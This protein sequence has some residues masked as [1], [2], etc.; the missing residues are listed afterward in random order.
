MKILTQISDN[1]SQVIQ[2]F[3]AVSILKGVLP[4]DV[5]N[6]M[7]KYIGTINSNSAD[8]QLVA[9]ISGEQSHLDVNHPLMED[10][11]NILLKGCF[12]YQNF[13]SRDIHD[14]D[15]T[16]RTITL[17]S[18]WSVKMN[19]N[20][21]NPLHV[22]GTDARSGL[23]TICYI[24][25]PEHIRHNAVKPLKS[26]TTGKSIR[27]GLLQ[28]NWQSQNT[29]AEDD[30]CPEYHQLIIPIVGEYYI[31]PKWLSHTVYPY[32]GIEQRW[33][34]QTNFNVYTDEELALQNGSKN[35]HKH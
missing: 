26:V 17:D 19:Q 13:M 14:V 35:D 8:A 16:H 23:A 33:S 12:T 27:D 5:I 29:S 32:H 9:T 20:D 34:V 28:F 10:F 11:F 6:N 4:V 24:K 1:N 31:F 7:N 30:Y 3:P 2:S 25:I 21:Y 15:S 18:C 22:H